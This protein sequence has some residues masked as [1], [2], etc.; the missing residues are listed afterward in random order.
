MDWLSEDEQF[1]KTLN[2]REIGRIKDREL[3]EIRMRHWEYRRKVFLDEHNISD[4]EFMRLTDA[5]YENEAREIEEYKNR[6]TD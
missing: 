4:E 3:R 5:D 6:R 1:K 2:D